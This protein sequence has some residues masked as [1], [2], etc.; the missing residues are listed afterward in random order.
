MDKVVMEQLY[1]SFSSVYPTI[2]NTAP[3][4]RTGLSPP[5]EVWDTPYQGAHYHILGAFFF[6]LFR[7]VISDL[8]LSRLR[9][10]EIE[11]L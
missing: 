2:F 8:E 9:N 11:F 10:E 1:F 6:F 5:P 4:L 7:L 3:L